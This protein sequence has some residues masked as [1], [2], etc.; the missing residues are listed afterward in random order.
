[1]ASVI[2][3]IHLLVVNPCAAFQQLET[4]G[5]YI[6]TNYDETDG[7]PS[8]TI[9]DIAFGEDGYLYLAS[10]A[11]LVRMDGVHIDV[12]SVQNDSG[13]KSDRI[14]RIFNLPNALIIKDDLGMVYR[15]KDGKAQP[16]VNPKNG[17][18]INSS[19][20]KRAGNDRYFL[21]DKYHAYIVTEN[22]IS[23]LSASLANYKLWDASLAADSTF[24]ILNVD[25]FYSLKN[26]NS[27]KLP[28]LNSFSPDL[29]F[30]SRIIEFDDKLHIISGN[31][32]AC[33]DTKNKTWCIDHSFVM[34]DEQEEIM[35]ICSGLEK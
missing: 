16:L 7:L 8:K 32:I 2:L 27:K 34:P 10:I 3:G 6:I 19:V 14:S 17:S 29:S 33:Y 5:R 12:F 25:G 23:I 4:T 11:G 28:F 13:F 26:E 35:H 30:F 24:Y 15:F 22:T 9:S 1:M 20:I 31:K 18:H 21:L